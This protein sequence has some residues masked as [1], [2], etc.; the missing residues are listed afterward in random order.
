VTLRT[1]AERARALRASGVF[2]AVAAALRQ[3]AKGDDRIAVKARELEA[4]AR[5]VADGLRDAVLLE[6][7]GGAGG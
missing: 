4:Q 1:P 6:E 2:A 5:T 3:V 7:T